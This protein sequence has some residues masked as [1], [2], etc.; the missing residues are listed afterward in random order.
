MGGDYRSR[1]AQIAQ[2]SAA[3]TYGTLPDLVKAVFTMNQL[4]RYAR[5]NKGLGIPEEPARVL[6]LLHQQSADFD[7]WYSVRL[8]QIKGDNEAKTAE[9]EGG[10]RPEDALFDLPLSPF[11]KFIE[12]ITHVRWRFHRTYLTQLLDRLLQKNTEYGALAQGKARANARRWH[13][14][15]R[16]LE[17]FVQLAVLRWD[18]NE[19]PKRFHSEPI[20]IDD[21]LRWLEGRYGF[22][23]GGATLPGG[24]RPVT[25]DE[26]AAFR[27]N[28]RMLKDQLREIGFFDDLS[29]AYNAQTIRPRY[30]IKT[31]PGSHDDH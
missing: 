3:A 7:A 21:F 1:M 22:V 31:E 29:D 23:I 12:L 8:S 30:A 2:A 4:L 10:K 25:A 11:E 16:L 15:G 28:V 13:L 19:G 20:L 17:V 24:P 14:G 27:A 5:E 26:Q 18:E 9:A 6:E